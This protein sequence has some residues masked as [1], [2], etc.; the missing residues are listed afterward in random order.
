MK[1]RIKET[2]DGFYPQE[3]KC[4]FSDWRYIGPSPDYTLSAFLS[5]YVKVDSIEKAIE[6][7]ESRKKRLKDI[8]FKKIHNFKIKK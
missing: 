5:F 7:I 3:K 4:F 2:Y 1:Y 8:E 6:R